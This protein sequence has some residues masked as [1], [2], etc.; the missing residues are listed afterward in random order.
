MSNLIKKI[1]KLLFILITIAIVGYVTWFIYDKVAT[2]IIESKIREAGINPDD[3][4]L[5]DI[6]PWN[7][8]EFVTEK[9]IEKIENEGFPAK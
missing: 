6:A 4:D 8:R 1:T 2:S 3:Y 7:V 9:E 5:S